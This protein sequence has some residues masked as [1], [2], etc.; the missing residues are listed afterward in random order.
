[1]KIYK[2]VNDENDLTYYGSTRQRLC[3]RMA[4][5][6][7]GLKRYL[8]NDDK[9]FCSSYEVMLYN[10]PQIILVEEIDCENKEQLRARERHYVETCPCVN[11]NIPNRNKKEWEKDHPDKLKIYRETFNK[12][13]PGYRKEYKKKWDNEHKEHNKEYGQE[14]RQK[15]KLE[16]ESQ[17][18]E[19]ISQINND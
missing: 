19:I 8:E 4:V 14:Y 6:R 10:N 5:H 7:T 11:R 1:M 12:K 2:I 16:K 13:H 3:Q 15:K 17:K 18:N 9:A